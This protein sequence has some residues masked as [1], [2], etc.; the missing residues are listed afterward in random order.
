MPK[1]MFT[2][3]WWSN[4][5]Q[6]LDHTGS[7]DTITATNFLPNSEWYVE[8]TNKDSNGDGN[9]EFDWRFI[10]LADLDTVIT[11]TT[12]GS[13]TS[14]SATADWLLSAANDHYTVAISSVAVLNTGGPNKRD[15][16][17]NWMIS[18]YTTASSE[19]PPPPPQPATFMVELEVK[20][21]QR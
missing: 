15:T 19:D 4:D 8:V 9:G 7:W 2:I 3:R 12:V 16:I 1:D 6:F 21:S 11:E 10:N 18:R 5:L 14:K 20:Q 17:M 13:V